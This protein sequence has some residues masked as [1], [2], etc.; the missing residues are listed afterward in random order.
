MHGL[1]LKNRRS[2]RTLSILLYSYYCYII[3]ILVTRRYPRH[4]TKYFECHNKCQFHCVFLNYHKTD[5]ILHVVKLTTKTGVYVCVCTQLQR[6][7]CSSGVHG[8]HEKKYLRGYRSKFWVFLHVSLLNYVFS[9]I[10]LY[11]SWF[12]LSRGYNFLKIFWC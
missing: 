9:C 2:I 12:I 5:T 8:V 3:Q 7:K 6:A 11:I 4:I 1:P 10:Y